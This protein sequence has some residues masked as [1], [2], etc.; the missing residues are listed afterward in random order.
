MD[1][2]VDDE[3]VRGPN[4]PPP[5]PRAP[6]RCLVTI[7]LEV[8]GEPANARAAVDSLL[9]AQ[10]LQRLINRPAKAEHGPLRVTSALATV[11]EV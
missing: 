1:R 7:E 9:G 11:E 8:E 2:L 4:D 3:A 5:P 6:T 10:P